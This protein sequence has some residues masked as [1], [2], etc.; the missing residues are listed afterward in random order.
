MN[1]KF[2]KISKALYLFIGVLAFTLAWTDYLAVADTIKFK[3][4]TANPSSLKKQRVPIKVYLPEEVK[5]A[6]ILDLGGLN[7]E[8]DSEKSLYYVYRDDVVLDAKQIRA[9]DVEIQDVWLIGQRDLD[10]TNERID[11]LLKVTEGSQYYDQVKTISGDF[12]VLSKNILT[13]QTNEDLTRSQHIGVYRTNKRELVQLKDRVTEIEKILQPPQGPLTPEML[14]KLKFKTESPTKTATWIA[15]FVIM[16][17]L[18]LISII[19]FVTW[20]RQGK[21][22]AKVLSEAKKSTFTDYGDKGTPPQKESQ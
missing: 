12:E 14:A 10:G 21:A 9:F 18:G 15:I 8:F 2:L 3:I 11:R 7:L 16:F 22:T 19:I 4:V 13:T 17:F 1:K 6:D 5:P 20:Y